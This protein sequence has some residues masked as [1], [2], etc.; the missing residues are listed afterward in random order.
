MNKMFKPQLSFI[1]VAALVSVATAQ[2]AILWGQCDYYL[3]H[4]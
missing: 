1:S 4:I 2:T 3:K